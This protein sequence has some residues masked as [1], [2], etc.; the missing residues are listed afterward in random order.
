MQTSLSGVFASILIPFT[1]AYPRIDVRITRDTS[2][3][4]YAKLLS[5]EIDT[6]I[7]SQ[8]PFAIPK[9]CE[10]HVL[11]EEPFVVLTPASLDLSGAPARLRK[12]RA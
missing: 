12:Q 2:S 6:A 4:L 10:W 11:R 9:T 1:R 3:G 7:T 8:P 5:G